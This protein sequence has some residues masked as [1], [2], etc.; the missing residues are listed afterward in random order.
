VG[1]LDIQAKQKGFP[2]DE[3]RIAGTAKD[4]AGKAQE[5]FGRVTGDVKSQVEGVAR[6][7]AGSAQDLY[8]EAKD[9]VA[10]AAQAVRDTA[11]DAEDFVRRTIETRPYT[12]A[13]VALAAGFLIGRLGRRDYW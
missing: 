8:G 6:Q 4:I 11:G 7:A 3:N 2:M 13:A 12:A 9:S 10:N 5:G 1:S